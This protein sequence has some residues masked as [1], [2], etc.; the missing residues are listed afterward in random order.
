MKKYLFLSFLMTILFAAFQGKCQEVL[1]WRGPDRT[2]NYH[3]SNLLKS[4]PESGPSMMWENDAIGNGYG[5]PVITLKNI[6]VNGEVDTVNYLFALDL[7]GKTIWKTPVG[8][9]WILSYPGARS[10]PTV[11]GDLIYVTTGLG[12]LACLD[13]KTGKEKWS[14][15]MISDFHGN[16]PRFGFSESVMVDEDKVYCS[17]GNADTNVVAL[18]R[19]TGTIIWIST[20]AGEMT[21]YCSPMLI[22]LPQRNVLVTFSQSNMIGIDAKDGKVLWTYKQEGEEVDVQANTPVYENGIIYFVNGNGN[23]A[24]KIKLSEDGS[25]ITELWRNSKCDNITGGFIKVNDCIYTSGYEKRFWYSLETITGKM[26]DSL[27]FDRGVTISADG[28][29]YLYNEK[30]QL[31]LFNPSGPKMEMV[32][33]FKVTRGTKAH[34]AHPVICNGILYVRHGK[35]LLAYDIRKK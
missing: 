28:M 31:G 16:V 23:G 11:V 29:L 20:G 26:T 14:V 6:F 15:N 17:P 21:S 7:S 32:S 30:G 8:K 3:E 13:T 33:S 10:T 24:V 1:E 19:Y 2:G 35:S 4:W 9:E 12:N 5:S 25:Q 27:K 34:Y 18:N 22:R